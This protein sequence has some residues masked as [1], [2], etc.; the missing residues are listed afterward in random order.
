MC[1]WYTLVVFH[2]VLR[3]FTDTWVSTG[4]TP[5]MFSSRRPV[6]HPAFD[7]VDVAACPRVGVLPPVEAFDT[8]SLMIRRRVIDA[9]LDVRLKPGKRGSKTFDPDSVILTWK[10]T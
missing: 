1:Q 8:A 3:E 2:G 5:F 10:E 4:R 7:R 6:V 9:L